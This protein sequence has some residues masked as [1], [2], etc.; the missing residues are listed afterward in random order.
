MNV[1]HNS[2]ESNGPAGVTEQS[3]TQSA[4]GGSSEKK[5]REDQEDSPLHLST[6]DQCATAQDSTQ[7]TSPATTT[8]QG[9]TAP[10]GTSTSNITDA[11]QT[12]DKHQ[13]R[14][15]SS[16]SHAQG[17]PDYSWVAQFLKETHDI[18][19]PSE[20]VTSA[21][22]S[23]LTGL[24]LETYGSASLSQL[25]WR[26]TNS[27]YRKPENPYAIVLWRQPPGKMALSQKQQAFRLISWSVE[28]KEPYHHWHIWSQDQDN[29]LL[30]VKIYCV[31]MMQE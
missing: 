30:Q 13:T 28:S 6:A 3:L 19:W 5:S 23:L 8:T 16:A 11:S 1:E 9:A 17:R 27:S 26:D 20:P 2:T 31:T 18:L 29:R 10:G 15:F 22:P 12:A 21:S 25:T 4:E 7:Q 14:T 24:T